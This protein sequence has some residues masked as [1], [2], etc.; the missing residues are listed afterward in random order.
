MVIDCVRHILTRILLC[1][2]VC[3]DM[4]YVLYDTMYLVCDTW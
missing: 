3:G 1:V 4:Y 2:C